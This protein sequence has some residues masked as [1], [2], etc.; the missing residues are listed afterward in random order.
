MP[1]FTG[2]KQSKAVAQYKNEWLEQNF[3]LHDLRNMVRADI[4][5]A[6]SD[7]RRSRDQVELFGTGIIPQAQQTVS[8]MLAG[9]Q[10]NKVDFLNLISAQVTLYNYEISY[11]QML[12][13]ANQA[14]A[15]VIA[16]VGAETIY[17]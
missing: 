6:V 16:T 9:Y 1:L 2:R 14:L 12:S 3:K 11:W 17:E 10:V 8:S 15:K 4:S 7:Y 5:A 13:E